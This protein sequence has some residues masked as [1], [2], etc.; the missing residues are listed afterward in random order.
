MVGPNGAGKSTLMNMLAGLLAPSEGEARVAGLDLAGDTIAV[1]RVCGI[2]P[3]NLGLFDDLTVEE[4]L[5]L[6]GTVYGLSVAE[7]KVRS[8]K[9]LR[10]LA[11]EHGRRTFLDHC[12]H[13]MRK[14]TALAMALLHNP[15]V[16]FLDEP[17]EG[18]DPLTART[19]GD[20]FAAMARCGVTVYLTSHILSI[21]DRLAGRVMVLR[22]GRIV[23]DS[24]AAGQPQSLEDVYFDLAGNPA[25]E[26]VPWLGL[27]QS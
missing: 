1:N 19:I 11:L 9:L 3:E 8:G 18:I 17:F 21:V 26:D 25:V 27:R 16:L 23:W 4:H 14:K 6:S 13:G 22:E 7:T 10:L 2:L 20:L 24:A 15:R 12:S 5:R